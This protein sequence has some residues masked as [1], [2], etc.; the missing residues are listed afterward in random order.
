MLAAAAHQHGAGLWQTKCLSYD[1][2]MIPSHTVVCN[3][4]YV[5]VFVCVNPCFLVPLQSLPGISP[6]ANCLQF[7]STKS[8]ARFFSSYICIN[9]TLCR[10][11]AVLK[12]L[13]HH[14]VLTL[15][16]QEMPAIPAPQTF[17]WLHRILFYFLV[18]L[19]HQ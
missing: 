4:N 5:V 8:C 18:L 2:P 7:L 15:L 19:S 17:F 3:C 12:S 14:L 6:S 11:T 16:T 9:A 1:E 13:T 10:L